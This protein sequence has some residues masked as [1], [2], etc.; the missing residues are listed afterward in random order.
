[1][2]L[3]PEEMAV[4]GK[5]PAGG[6]RIPHGELLARV[7]QTGLH[8]PKAESVLR[9][10]TR[11]GLTDE[12]PGEVRATPEGMKAV[13]ETVN[14]RWIEGEQ[15]MDRIGQNGNEGLHHGAD[16]KVDHTEGGSCG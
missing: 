6:K 9:R 2:K 8:K 11:A 15:R 5:L 12:P 14:L 13:I 10:L 3:T 16:P 7:E 4:I 1:M